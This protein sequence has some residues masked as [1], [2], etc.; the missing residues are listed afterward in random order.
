[1]ALE[2]FTSD[3]GHVFTSLVRRVRHTLRR[4][5]S[6]LGRR[7]FACDDAARALGLN[8]STCEINYLLD[9]IFSSCLNLNI[10]VPLHVVDNGRQSAT[11]QN[12][13]LGRKLH[14]MRSHNPKR[15][16]SKGLIEIR[17][18]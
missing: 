10:L 16:S 17:G 11:A 9:I 2:G 7:L 15:I 5:I 3:I 4:D 14:D 8:F 13:A 1:M 18:R 6:D 12:F